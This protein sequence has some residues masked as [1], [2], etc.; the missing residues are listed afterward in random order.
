[1]YFICSFQWCRN[2]S[3]AE[4]FFIDHVELEVALKSADSKL[5]LLIFTCTFSLRYPT[6][7]EW[8]KFVWFRLFYTYT[9]VFTKIRLFPNA[10]WFLVTRTAA[11]WIVYQS[12]PSKSTPYARIRQLQHPPESHAL[13]CLCLYYK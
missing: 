3:S 5:F 12:G 9:K 10:F 4:K 7:N 1:V 2:Y 13:Y 6:G 11:Q 8:A